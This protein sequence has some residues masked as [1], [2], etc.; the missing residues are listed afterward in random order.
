MLSNN[1]DKEN[2]KEDELLAIKLQQQEYLPIVNYLDEQAMFALKNWLEAV[3]KG[4]SQKEQDKLNQKYVQALYDYENQR[5]KMLEIGSTYLI[6]TALQKKPEQTISQSYTVQPLQTFSEKDSALIEEH[7]EK[8]PADLKI[9]LDAV[10]KDENIKLEIMT[11]P[12]FVKG[13]GHVYDLATVEKIIAKG[14]KNPLNEDMKFKKE[15][16]IPCNTLIK[17]VQILFAIISG[18]E[19]SNK[20]V[21]INQF[22]QDALDKTMSSKTISSEL[23]KVIETYYQ[24]LPPKHQCLFD[25]ICRDPMT[26]MI[27]NDPVF[28]PD[29]YAYNRSTAEFLLDSM[30]SAPCYLDKNISFKKDDITKCYLIF[31]VFESLQKMAKQNIVPAMPVDEIRKL[32]INNN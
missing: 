18:S 5:E 31:S 28:L 15:D 13:D 25:I 16:I 7:Y 9:L 30:E 6:Q 26:N 11:N 32:T 12:V 4:V 1:K 23:I 19:F 14:G 2:I 17:A 21:E 3:D 24:T 20:P 10:L 29:G 22:N 8:I 27:M